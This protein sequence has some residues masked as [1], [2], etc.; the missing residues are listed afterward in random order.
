MLGVTSSPFLLTGTLIHYL[1]TFS[2]IDSEFVQRVLKSVH[3]DDLCSVDASI[4]SAYNFYMKCNDRLLQAN[5][6]LHKF[7]SNSPELEQMINVKVYEL[8]IAKILGLKSDKVNDTIIFNM[9]KLETLMIIKPT[10]RELIQFFASIY[11]PLGLINPFIVSFKCLFQKVYISKVNWDA[12]LPRG[13]LKVWHNIILDFG[14][15]NGLVVPRW[16]GHLNSVNR[17]ELHGFSDVSIGTYVSCIYIR[18]TGQDRLIHSSLV[19]SKSRV[20]HIKPMSIPKLEFQGVTL[21]G[22]VIMQF[23]SELPSF[24][25]TSSIHCWCDSMIV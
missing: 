7:E 5:F 6:T 25:H 22:H 21:L 15:S 12:I 2:S 14:S 10:K 17:V 11:D 1:I 19:T 9:K 3:V 8:S 20:S 4:Q 24:I 16:Y 13:I 18:I 23:H